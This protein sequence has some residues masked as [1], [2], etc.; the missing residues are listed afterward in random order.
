MHKQVSKNTGIAVYFCDP[1]SPWAGG[2]NENMYW[3]DAPVTAQ[4]P[5]LEHLKRCSLMLSLMRL[6]IGRAKSFG[7]EIT[8][9]P[10]PRS[11]DQQR[12][13]FPLIH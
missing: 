10:L 12:L 1:H 6:T 9:S 11:A 4:R 3:S 8:A 5:R 13:A 7:D 2:T